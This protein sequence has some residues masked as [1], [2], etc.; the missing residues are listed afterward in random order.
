MEHR[1]VTHITVPA[2]LLFLT[3][4]PVIMAGVR[5]VQIPMD[6][7]PADSA[8]FAATPLAIFAHALSGVLFGV[9]GPLQFGRA[10]AG[11]FGHLHRVTGRIFV[12]AGAV[13]ALSGLRLVWEF[14]GTSTPVLD[15]ARI[16]ASIGL[17]A[18]L[19]LAIKAARAR[20]IATHRAWMI[21]AY[22]IGMGA[23]TIAFI[24]FPIY[25]VTGEPLTGL[26]SDLAFVGS[27]VINIAIAEWVIARLRRASLTS[28]SSR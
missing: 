6:A 12:A 1:S 13:M 21:R 28:A 23:A 19:W 24:M 4:I 20:D 5:V 2:L 8:R 18:T 14:P 17:G 25:I 16:A 3:A 22:A 27:W 15:L 26:A 9:L 7:L 11:R 10:I